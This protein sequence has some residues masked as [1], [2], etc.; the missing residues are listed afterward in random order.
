MPVFKSVVAAASRVPEGNQ[1]LLRALAMRQRVDEGFGGRS[2][3]LGV[4]H[5][6]ADCL[7]K[8]RQ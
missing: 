5:M 2:Y 4:C 1:L 7:A 8:G 6:L 3:W